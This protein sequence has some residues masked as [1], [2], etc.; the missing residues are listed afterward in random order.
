MCC[1]LSGSKIDGRCFS[2]RLQLVDREMVV[3][4]GCGCGINLVPCLFSDYLRDK[5]PESL[6]VWSNQPDM[7]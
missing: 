3:V 7:Y 6:S 4:N 1:G 2:N 5:K